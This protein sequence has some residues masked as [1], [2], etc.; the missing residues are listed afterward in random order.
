MSLTQ[1]ESKYRR[2]Q[3]PVSKSHKI[4]P[5]ARQQIVA[6]NL[7]NNYIKLLKI[8]ISLAAKD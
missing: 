3:Q 6:I 8:N 1:L 7:A 5:W 2:P 4:K